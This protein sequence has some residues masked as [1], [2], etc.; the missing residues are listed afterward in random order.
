MSNYKKIIK[1]FLVAF[2]LGATSG[3][4]QECELNDDCD[5]L[6]WQE[7]SVVFAGW[8]DSKNECSCRQEGFI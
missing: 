2:V 7:C 1:L 6:C 5:D 4:G 8:C 3:C